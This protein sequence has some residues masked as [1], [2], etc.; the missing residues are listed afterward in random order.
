MNRKLLFALGFRG[1]GLR[2]AKVSAR[3]TIATRLL[4]IALL[5]FP[6]LSFACP[7]GQLASKVDLI[8][9]EVDA[10]K[11]YRYNVTQKERKLVPELS[12]VVAISQS[13]INCTFDAKREPKWQTSAEPIFLVMLKKD[14][15]VW[16]RGR[17]W[18]YWENEP[19]VSRISDK[20]RLMLDSPDRFIRIVEAIESYKNPDTT[21]SY[22]PIQPFTN[23]VRIAAGESFFAAID[24]D[25][26][27]WQWGWQPNQSA[28]L[29]Y[30]P[31]GGGYGS[32]PSGRLQLSSFFR[33]R[34]Y[35]NVRNILAYHYALYILGADGVIYYRGAGVVACE[36]KERPWSENELRSIK[37][38]VHSS[39]YAVIDRR[40]A[41]YIPDIWYGCAIYSDSDTGL[42][43]S[44]ENPVIRAW[45]NPENV[46][47]C[48]AEFRTGERWTWP[49]YDRSYRR[50][51]RPAIRRPTLSH[52]E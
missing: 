16:V 48:N 41:G 7:P 38:V 49:C 11:V 22:G 47:E 33:A 21:G 34:A 20:P 51:D 10:G 19:G 14:G 39:P 28:E 46:S 1:A 23:I 26:R 15:T 5:L 44:S 4:A 32:L 3:L 24:R 17:V 37:S 52:L 18:A 6:P 25:G 42:F 43:G 30:G 50:I 13:H 31:S 12:D 35:M 9:Y 45:Q 2:L 27:L 40:E 29:G 8:R 36:W